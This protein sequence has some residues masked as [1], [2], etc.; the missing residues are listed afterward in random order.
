[1]IR[2]LVFDFD[3]LIL[4][5]ETAL[6]DAWAAVHDRAGVAYTREQA[7]GVVGHVDVE[8]DPWAGFDPGVSRIALEEERR[9]ISRQLLAALPVLPGVLPL[10]DA[11]R[12]A[13][14]RVGLASNSPHAWVDRHLARIRLF[15][16]FETICC[17]DDVEHGKPAPDLYL[18][19]LRT[20]G[21]AGREA[22]SFEDSPPGSE[23]AKRAGL[24]SVVVPNPSTRHREFPFADLRLAS[25][26]EIT[27]EKLVTHFSK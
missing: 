3:G 11:A 20:F 26:A 5:T 25:L 8:F 27:L 23:A 17:R 21:V 24:H 19:V 12:T 7:L 1:M 6:I 14:L 4:D 10:L 22:I 15:D 13:G 16:R 2:A 9:K 18:H